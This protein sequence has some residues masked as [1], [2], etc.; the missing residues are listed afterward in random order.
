MPFG[1]VRNRA[2]TANCIAGRYSKAHILR[3]QDG[4]QV[5]LVR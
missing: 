3:F 1:V 4:I 2:I 5:K